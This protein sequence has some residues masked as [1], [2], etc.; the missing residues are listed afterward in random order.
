M[1]NDWN[2]ERDSFIELPHLENVLTSYVLSYFSSADTTQ[3]SVYRAIT[4]HI[5]R[6]IY[7]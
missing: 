3:D 7:V 4:E 5:K 2:I 6:D 1:K